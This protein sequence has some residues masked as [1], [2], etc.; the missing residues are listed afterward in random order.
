[1]FCATTSVC[2]DPD[3][4]KRLHDKIARAASPVIIDNDWWKN[5]MHK[6]K[7][8][9]LNFG[10]K[11]ISGAHILCKDRATLGKVPGRLYVAPDQAIDLVFVANRARETAIVSWLA[12]ACQNCA[13]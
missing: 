12:T 10:R 7:L 4:Q 3:D 8:N 6:L 1:M 2:S 11:W 5:E 13:T 9:G